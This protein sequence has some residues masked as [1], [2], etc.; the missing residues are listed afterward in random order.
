MRVGQTVAAGTRIGAVGMS[1]N[2]TGPHCHFETH[3]GYPATPGN[4]TDPIA[5]M[6]ARGV[7]I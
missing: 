5:F 2:A 7:T 1:G 6:A 4:A 3:T